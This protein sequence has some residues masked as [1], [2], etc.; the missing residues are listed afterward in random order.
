MCKAQPGPGSQ[1]AAQGLW[2]GCMVLAWSGAPTKPAGAGYRACP[3]L[4]SIT[5]RAHGKAEP[6][7]KEDITLLI[8]P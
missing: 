1:A 4:Y 7:T 3:V 5:V 6:D 8:H 2:K